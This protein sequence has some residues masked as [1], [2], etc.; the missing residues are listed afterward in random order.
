MQKEQF[1]TIGGKRFH[2]TWLRDNCLNSQ[3]R[4]PD[5]LE[6][7]ND[8]CDRPSH[9]QPKFI[10]ERDGNLI[11]DWNENPPLRSVFPISWLLAHTCD[12]QPQSPIGENVILWDKAWL[13]ANPIEWPDVRKSDFK[14]WIE[15]LL[16]LGFIILR[17][18]PLEEL[19]TFISSFGP[20]RNTEYGGI[21]T[22]KVGKDLAATSHGIPPHNDLTFWYGHR[23]TQFIHCAKNEAAGGQTFTI[24]GFRVA[25]DFRENHPDYF[26]ILAETP[27]QFWRVQHEHQY[28]FR[29]VAS[30]IEVDKAGNTTAI[31]F[32]HKNCVPQLPF[33]QLERFYE[34]YTAFS[35]YLNNPDYQYRF[36][37]TAG[38]CLLIQNFRA[39]HGRTDYDATVGARDFRV[40][41]M[42]WDY[43]LARYFYQRELEVTHFAINGN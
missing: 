29:P 26:Q 37:L 12:P 31:R 6:K 21:M 2:Y 22:Q 34:A 27:I 1:V 36:R 4:H 43:F 13:E 28:F 8:I 19:D 38:D 41:Y 24:D 3:N 18:I 35:R 14:M 30:I 10:E 32:S 16:S 23:T 42:E 20:V 39:L 9:P 40:A 11:V 17:N 15:Q 33:D 7:L 5:S 25:K